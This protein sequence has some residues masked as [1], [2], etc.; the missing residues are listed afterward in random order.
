MAIADPARTCDRCGARLARDNA[1]TRCSSCRSV[2]N[3]LAGPPTVPRSFW[4]TASMCEALA[5]WHM[6]RV[7]YTYRIHPWHPRQLS[8]EIVGNWLGLTQAQLSRIENGH[9]PEEMSKLIHY[10]RVLGI[11]GELLWFKLPERDGADRDAARREPA[12][13]CRS[14]W[15]ASRYSCP[16]MTKPLVLKG[17]TRCLISLSTRSMRQGSTGCHCLFVPSLRS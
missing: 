14:W 5:T 11:P 7:I 6:G 12:R 15:A 1:D 13:R 16:S 9:A 2:R 4:D 8:Q 17:L 3:L 10:A